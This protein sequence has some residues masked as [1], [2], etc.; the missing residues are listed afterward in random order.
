M[1]L[2]ELALEWCLREAGIIADVINKWG[3]ICVWD[4]SSGQKILIWH[5]GVSV[6]SG[7]S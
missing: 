4:V 6:N 3:A 1:V 5:C 7:V 2:V